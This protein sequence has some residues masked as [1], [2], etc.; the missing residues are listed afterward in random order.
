VPFTLH[1]ASSRLGLE[2]KGTLGIMK[3]LMELGKFRS[4]TE[5]LLQDLKKM[6]FRV[7]DKIFWEIFRDIHQTS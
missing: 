1:W 3:R 7:K 6:D 2:V 5:A 4:S